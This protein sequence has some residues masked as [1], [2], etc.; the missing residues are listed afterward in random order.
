MGKTEQSRFWMI[1][2]PVFPTE[3]SRFSLEGS[4]KRDTEPKEPKR[5]PKEPKEPRVK[6][7]TVII[8]DWVPSEAWNGYLSMRI[9][10]KKAPTARAVE[11]LIGRLARF[12]A[13][14]HSLIEILDESTRN[15]WTDVYAPKN[16]TNFQPRG[17]P[18]NGARASFATMFDLETD[19]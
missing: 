3:Q 5:N 14:G 15:G 9:E 4:R 1:R 16:G 11:L 7:A 13:E 6:S 8:P 18:R 12:Q 10:K 17:S 2:G 19:Q